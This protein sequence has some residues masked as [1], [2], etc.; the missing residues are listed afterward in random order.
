MPSDPDVR[1][2]SSCIPLG[3]V[4]DAIPLRTPVD[5]GELLAELGLAPASPPPQNG[6][7]PQHTAHHGTATLR[8]VVRGFLRLGPAAT[9]Q[10]DADV[11]IDEDAEV[12]QLA[13]EAAQTATTEL[14]EKPGP[15]EDIRE[16]ADADARIPYS[17]PPVPL[18]T[19]TA[20]EFIAAV[21]VPD[22]GET[23]RRIAEEQENDRFLLNRDQLF[24]PTEPRTHRGLI[25]AA[26]LATLGLAVVAAAL[27]LGF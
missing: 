6:A 11:R 26:L 19:Q 23:D 12:L 15:R 22:I 24:H 9:T 8:E 20:P 14:L 3:E 13:P 1:S 5:V 10:V 21:P 7:A 27:F 17:A 4:V 2:A 18:E 25:V 16:P